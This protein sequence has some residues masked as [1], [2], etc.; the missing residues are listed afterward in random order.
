MCQGGNCA[1]AAAHQG[2]RVY[3]GALDQ[4]AAC[5][6]P[7]RNGDMVPVGRLQLETIDAPGHTIGSIMLLLHAPEPALFSGDCLFCGGCGAAME[8]G[9]DDIFAAFA[10]IWR[11]LSPHPG[12]MIFPGHEYTEQLLGHCMADPSQCPSEKASSYARLASALLKARRRRDAPGLPLPTIPTCLADELAFNPYFYKLHQ[13]A[14]V[15]TDAYRFKLARAAQQPGAGWRPPPPSDADEYVP[16]LHPWDVLAPDEPPRSQQPPL[17]A[18]GWA[19]DGADTNPTLVLVSSELVQSLAERQAKAASTGEEP[20]ATDDKAQSAAELAELCRQRPHSHNSFD[21]WAAKRSGRL[22]SYLV[23]RRAYG[24]EHGQRAMLGALAQLGLVGDYIESEMLAR[25]VST[26]GLD[27]PLSAQETRGLL[28]AA[29]ALDAASTA[30]GSPEPP[31]GAI[32]GAA[33][34]SLL[35][36]AIDELLA[37]RPP[38]PSMLE[39]TV[40]MLAA[41]FPFQSTVVMRTAETSD[42]TDSER[43]DQAVSTRA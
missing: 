7:L 31:L 20:D 42:D 3:G 19:L 23:E 32:S 15:L 38:P 37:A 13:A 30:D 36:S 18:S 26:L 17:R 5:T 24:V 27:S 4:V 11:R 35:A 40:G 25:C 16:T 34:V 2:L 33:L 39:R 21:D 9:M 28:A 12:N 8:G 6:H 10:T 41:A 1:I 14:S 22:R 43:G 29:R